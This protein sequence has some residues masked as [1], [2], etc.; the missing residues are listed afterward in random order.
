MTD[1]HET[2]SHA[3][4][5]RSDCAERLRELEKA[6]AALG[7]DNEYAGGVRCSLSVKQGTA[8]VVE[9]PASADLIRPLIEAAMLKERDTLA[10]YDRRLEAARTAMQRD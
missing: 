1:A 6:M 2:L 5:L 3:L 4:N 10:K 8:W 9:T 7:P